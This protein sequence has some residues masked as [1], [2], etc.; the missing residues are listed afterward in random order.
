M[1]KLKQSVIPLVLSVP[2]IIAIAGTL[3]YFSYG[4]NRSGAWIT[5]IISTISIYCLYRALAKETKT[6]PP[7][8]EKIIKNITN[9]EWLLG[10]LFLITWLIAVYLLFSGRSERAIITPWQVVPVWFFLAYALGIAWLFL[11]GRFSSRLVSIALVLQSSLLFG[12]ALIVYRIG[13]GFDPFIHEAAVNAIMKLGQIKPLTPYYLGQYSLITVLEAFSGLK[14]AFLAKML[15]PSLAALFLPLLAW[16]WLARHHGVERDWGLAVIMALIL[17][18]TIFIVTTPQSLAYIFLLIA[19]LWPTPQEKK[20]ELII[21]WLNAIAALVTQPIAGIPAILVAISDTTRGRRFDKKIYPI[22]LGLFVV[23]VPAALYIFTKLGSEA[24]ISFQAPELLKTFAWLA[25]SN[26]SEKSWWLNFL[27]LYGNNQGLIIAFLALIGVII[28][29]KKKSKELL[30]RF[31]LPA[32]ALTLC[33]LLTSSLNFHF[34]INYERSDYLE[35]VLIVVAI[36]CLPLILLVFRAIAAR[37]ENMPRKIVAMWLILIVSGSLASLYLSY[38]RFDDYANSHGYAT[39]K[40]DI[41][42]VRFI[43][44][45]ARGKNYIVLAN[46]QVSAAALR[47]FGFNRY[48][49]NLFYYPIPTGGALY[50]YYLKMVDSP[51]RALMKEAMDLTRVDRVYLVLN[52]YWWQFKELAPT[53][54]AMANS[55][56]DIGDGQIKIFKFTR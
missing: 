32:I 50:Q 34:L 56:G 6:S 1:N 2:A 53:I 46:Q 55:T 41:L 14:T 13:Y 11:L 26:P 17:P 19:L 48:Y 7:R 5:I 4:L 31:A 25:P 43:E 22:I 45:D 28:A 20:S 29:F 39:S 9:S 8:D 35:R 40:A 12:V 49:N 52:N 15:V 38:P 30:R 44:Q 10:A 36:F 24:A 47:E 42:A 16:R 3:V 23:A 37:V 51:D 21:V 54:G 18:A 27:Y 33:A